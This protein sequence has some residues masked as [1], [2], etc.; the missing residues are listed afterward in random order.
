MEFYEGKVTQSNT[1]PF[2]Q[3]PLLSFVGQIGLDDNVDNILSR[4]GLAPS[5]VSL[6]ILEVLEYSALK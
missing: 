1:T 4:R 5:D 6:E 3:E 2:I